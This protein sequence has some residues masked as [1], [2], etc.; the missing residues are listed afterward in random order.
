MTEEELSALREDFL[1]ELS[2]LEQDQVGYP[3]LFSAA[4]AYFVLY[5][6]QLALRHPAM[7]PG[8]PDSPVSGLMADWLRALATDIQGRLCKT[9]ALAKIAELG[10]QK[11]KEDNAYPV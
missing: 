6:L 4:E 1:R 2:D 7:R 5:A 8:A 3:F 9:P 11:I 10:W